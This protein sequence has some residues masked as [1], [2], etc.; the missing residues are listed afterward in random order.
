MRWSLLPLVLGACAP[1][2]QEALDPAALERLATKRF[3][4]EAYS[5]EIGLADDFACLQL[6]GHASDGNGGDPAPSV[7]EAMAR[8]WAIPVFP[9]SRCSIGEDSLVDAPGM[10]GEGKVVGIGRLS[11]D[12][13]AQ[14]CTASVSYYVANMAAGGTDLS[15]ERDGDGWVV[16]RGNSMW[17][18]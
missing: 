6:D 14:R 9:G 16:R 1:L 10:T 18:S 8:R 5:I 13:A 7:V 2:Q 4:D 3:Y 11:C 12:P 17:I 15:L